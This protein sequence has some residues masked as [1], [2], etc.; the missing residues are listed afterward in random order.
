MMIHLI[1]KCRFKS[2]SFWQW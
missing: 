1:S 2:Y